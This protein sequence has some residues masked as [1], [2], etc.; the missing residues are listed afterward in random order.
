MPSSSIK[1]QTN[2]QSDS[3]YCTQYS[4]TGV[5]PA[6]F[7]RLSDSALKPLALNTALMMSQ[8]DWFWKILQS[9]TRLSSQI[10]GRSSTW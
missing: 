4:S 10:H 3:R 9:C 7:C 1:R 2:A 5:L 6:W 8:G